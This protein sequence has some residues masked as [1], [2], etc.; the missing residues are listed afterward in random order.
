MA[1]ESVEIA[2]VEK[3]IASRL[4]GSKGTLYNYFNSKEE[5]FAAHV[6]THC[7]FHVAA[8]FEQPMEGDDPFAVLTG[9]AERLLD[10]LTT[11]ESACFYSLIV[12]ESQRNPSVGQIFY[13]SG[14]RRGIAHVAEFLERARE[15][16]KIA[17]EDCVQAATDFISLIHGG[18]PWRRVLNVVPPPS[19]VDIRK[20]A[21]RIARVFIRA[22]GARA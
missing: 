4:G 17:T 19:P 9:L 12:S 1:D 5:L 16:G 18:L 22:Y 8:A 20:E 11:D 15:Q 21:E 10:A 2:L 6:Q 13:E 14:P 7:Q 3:A